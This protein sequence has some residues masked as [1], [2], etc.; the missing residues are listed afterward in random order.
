[1]ARPSLRCEGARGVGAR[2]EARSG[3]GARP[4][5]ARRRDAARGDIA[6]RAQ[7][8]AAGARGARREP[9]R[10]AARG[11][12]PRQAEGQALTSHVRAAG[13]V[14]VR[15]C[16]DGVEVLV[17][18]RPKYLDWT[19]PKGKADSDETDEACAVREVEEETGLRCEL[20]EELPS[21]LYRD[22]CGRPKQSVCFGVHH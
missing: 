12:D 2:A 20:G 7:A 10:R 8:G 3:E 6:E 4:A 16:P 17:V 14:V 18:H 15:L 11:A 5:R 21:T 1:M 9:G 22:S 13:G 19:F